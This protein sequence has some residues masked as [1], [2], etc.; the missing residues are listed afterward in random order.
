MDKKEVEKKK[1]FKKRVKNQHLK[2]RVS[3]APRSNPPL[4]VSPEKVFSLGIFES[5]AGNDIDPNEHHHRHDEDYVG[6]PPFS[7]QVPQQSSLASVAIVA[8]LVLVIVPQVAVWVRRW[9]HWV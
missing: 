4:F 7:P 6:L 8:Q 9:V 5:T 2:S 1:K 3:V